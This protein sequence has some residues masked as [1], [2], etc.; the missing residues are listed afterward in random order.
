MR[1]AIRVV[2]V[3]IQV[4]ASIGIEKLPNHSYAAETQGEAHANFIGSIFG[5]WV[6]T[7]M[8]VQVSEVVYYNGVKGT[9]VVPDGKAKFPAV[10][11]IHEWW[12]LNSQIKEMASK[13]AELGYVALAVDLYGGK[14]TSD[15]KMARKY[16]GVVGGN[17]DAAF[18]NLRGAVAFLK[19]HGSVR[20][21]ALAA[22]G[23][24][25]GGGWSYQ[26]AKN[27]LGV[28]ASVIYYG[29]F[30]PQ[31]D[32]QKMRATIMGH[33]GAKDRGIK[34]DSVRAFQAT[35]KTLKGKHEV[36]IYE[37]AG[38]AFANAG[39]RNYEPGSANLAWSR[40]TKFLK[41]ALR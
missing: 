24:C 3:S 32:L 27:N 8:A 11:L 1:R 14:V 39:S 19:S 29:R 21:D 33:F 36:F 15:P 26:I 17:K 7:A 35:L 22:V 20:T 25:F 18:A 13:F 23:W 10:I 2:S 37:N 41:Q 40:T 5:V 16:A 34:E 6:Q 12:G 9:L 38:H 4:L 30:N 28:Q 31:D